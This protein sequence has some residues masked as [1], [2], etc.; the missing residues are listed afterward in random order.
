MNNYFPPAPPLQVAQWFNTDQPLSLD[1][2]RGKIVVL[3]AFQM[4]CPGCVSY[5]IPQAKAIHDTFP[6]DA[7]AVIGLHTV[8]EHHEAMTPEALRAFLHEYRIRFP[9]GVDQPSPQ[10]AIPRTMAAYAL[11]GTPSLVVI[12][13]AG[14]V[15]LSHFGHLDDLRVGATIG[16]LLR[17]PAPS[18]A[19]REAQR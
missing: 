7:V 14:R 2:L 16:Q 5:G 11:Q 12:D 19:D 8:F 1:T 4:L 10:G 15:R 6:H 17:D 18:D 9:V 3:H 13:K